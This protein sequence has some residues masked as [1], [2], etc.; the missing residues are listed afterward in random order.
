MQKN[1]KKQQLIRKIQQRW[2]ELDKKR[3]KIIMNEYKISQLTASKYIHMSEDEIQSLDNPTVYKPKKKPTNDYVNIIYKMYVAGI[4]PEVIF[5]YV[6][7]SGYCGTWYAL[8]NQIIRIL[9]NNF[10][11]RLPMK[12]YLKSEYP[13]DITVIK[14]NE[15]LNYI[16]TKNEKKRKMRK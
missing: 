8:D 13:Q 1:E 4:K 5:S 2:S 3:Y 6:C 9:K 12:W 14:R 15:V 16:T 11:V 7:K 10:G